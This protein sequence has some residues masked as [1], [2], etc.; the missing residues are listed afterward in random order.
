MSSFYLLLKELESSSRLQE[1]FDSTTIDLKDYEVREGSVSL[2]ILKGDILIVDGQISFKVHL[3][4]AR[5]GRGF[6]RE[7]SE[8]LHREF[9]LGRDP[10]DSN[11]KVRLRD[12][13]LDRVFFQDVGI[14]LTADIR[15]VVITAIPMAPHCQEDCKGI[16]P[17]CGQD[18]NQGSCD[19][20]QPGGGGWLDEYIKDQDK[21]AD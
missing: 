16:C 21:S 6:D 9:I 7:F 17:Y 2:D 20:Q 13:D 5:C 15:E 11:P 18:L 3:T 8:H 4:C 14:D 1:E 12:S 10:Y 19:C